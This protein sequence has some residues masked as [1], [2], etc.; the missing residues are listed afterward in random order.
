MKKQLLTLCFS[1]IGLLASG[2]FQEGPYVMTVS[3]KIAPDA[4]GRTLAH[5]HIATNFNGT[6]T[7]NHPLAGQ[8]QALAQL[9]PWLKDLWGRGYNSLVECTPAHIGRN[10]GLLRELAEK[11][12]MQILT[13]TGFYAA[14]DKKYLPEAA[15]THSAE[16]LAALWG[17]E[18]T[19]G[20][21]DT[22]I[23]PGFIKLGVGDGPLDP[24]ERKIVKAGML[25]S[26][27]T[28]LTVYV[29]TGGDQSIISQRQLA[30]ELGFKP[31]KLVWVHAQNGTDSTRIAMARQGMWVSLDGVSEERLDAYAG[32]IRNMKEAG[33]LHRLLLSHDDGWSVERDAPDLELELFANGN[34]RPYWSVEE[35]LLPKL[36][37]LGFREAELDQLLVQ[38]PRK[39]LSITP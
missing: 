24:V 21:G 5:E 20:I 3:G 9:L 4:L 18:G 15:Y 8:E 28:G 23:R 2:A 38:N 10:V 11:S 6:E 1:I 39:A 14:V 12:G 19:Y 36:R 30:L 26:G 34:K 27:R 35:L 33:L 29:H 7:G 25:L 22:G 16:E 17:Q 31:D 13:N 37:N 32:M